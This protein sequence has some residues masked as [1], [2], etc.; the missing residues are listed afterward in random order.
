MGRNI[1]TT[2]ADRCP[3]DGYVEAKMQ[4]RMSR[5]ERAALTAAVAC[6]TLATTC[7]AVAGE[8]DSP[9]EVVMAGIRAWAQELPNHEMAELRG[10]GGIFF[11]MRVDASI[12]PGNDGDMVRDVGAQNDLPAGL[13]PNVTIT[14]N[15]AEITMGI[16]NLPQGFSG[17]FQNISVPG[18]FNVVNN[19]ML[20]QVVIVQDA[21]QLAG[22]IGNLRGF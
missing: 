19:T 10:A 4:R 7:P 6:V 9:G 1:A 5:F 21:A 8:S 11:R 16:G 17:I 13:N 3:V 2:V 15:V 14:D 20:M 18:N 12:L 22:V